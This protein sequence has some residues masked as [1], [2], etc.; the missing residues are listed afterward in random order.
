MDDSFSRVVAER[1]RIVRGLVVFVTLS[2]AALAGLIAA[3]FVLPFGIGRQWLDLRELERQVDEQR[4][5]V[6]QDRE[7]VRILRE[8]L[9]ELQKWDRER[10]DK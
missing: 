4:I 9:S 10:R 7:E 3:N 1:T 8:R 2:V 6:A 5:Q